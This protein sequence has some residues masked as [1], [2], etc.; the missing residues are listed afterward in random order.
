MSVLGKKAQV[1]RGRGSQRS[2]ETG[3]LTAQHSLPPM[4]SLLSIGVGGLS[5]PGAPQP[6]PLD[7]GGLGWQP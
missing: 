6:L 1:R 4:S 2:G 5:R 7:K 3:F